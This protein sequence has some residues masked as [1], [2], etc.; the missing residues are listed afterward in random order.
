MPFCLSKTIMPTAEA[1][2]A[3]AACLIHAAVAEPKPDGSAL[4]APLVAADARPVEVLGAA[5]QVHS[6][7]EEL[8]GCE[9]P[10]GSS[11]VDS[12]EVDSAEAGQV[13]I[14]ERCLAPH[15]ACRSAQEARMD[16]L[17]LDSRR[18]DYS[19][20]ADS[21]LGGCSAVP[22]RGDRCELAAQMD[23]LPPACCSAQADQQQA[24][25][26]L[27]DCSLAA[28]ADHFVPAAQTAD[29]RVDF[30]GVRFPAPVVQDER[31]CSK[32]AW[33]PDDC[34]VDSPQEAV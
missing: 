15:S 22:F 27:D 26:V 31:N 5:E 25:P 12:A 18:A 2:P 14:E 28:W 32:P 24:V 34:Q 3:S 1:D 9:A 21:S 19:A 4:E 16:D 11:Q 13:A 30:Q 29:C 8:V 20:P 6:A 10:D 23:D 7:V 17:R 33:L